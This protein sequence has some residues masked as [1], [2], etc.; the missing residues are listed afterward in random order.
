MNKYQL[1]RNNL[2]QIPINDDYKDKIFSLASSH[3][4]AE[5]EDFI[6]TNSISLKVKNDKNETIIHALLKGESPTPENELLRCMKFLVE[7]GA[8]IS[9]ID[10]EYLTPLFICIKKEYPEIFKYLITQ[11][12]NT[13]IK[14][15]D[16]LNVLHVI[17]KPGHTIFDP[18]GIQDLIPERLPKITMEG[19][20]DV[21]KKIQ[22][23]VDGD[24][25]SL[26]TFADIA[27]Q[28]Y[29]NDNKEE[30]FNNILLIDKA[31]KEP[32]NIYTI[33]NELFEKL[34]NS[35]SENED[36]KDVNEEDQ[37]QTLLTKLNIEI[38]K[39][40]MLEFNSK[41]ELS[42]LNLAKN[43]E[44]CIHY[45]FLNKPENTN[46]AIDII[47]ALAERIKL[48]YP[49]GGGG[50]QPLDQIRFIL[51]THFD[52][53]REII[54]SILVLPTLRISNIR[55]D[56]YTFIN[57]IKQ[58]L[59]NHISNIPVGGGLAIGAGGSV[60]AQITA[61]S[62][63]GNIIS[64]LI[65]SP[66]NLAVNA[67]AGTI[68]QNMRNALDHIIHPIVVPALPGV[69]DGV[70]QIPGGGPTPIQQ[71]I[72]NAST[73]AI[74]IVTQVDNL[75]T[76]INTAITGITTPA[77]LVAIPALNTI[78]LQLKVLAVLQT[79]IRSAMYATV[80]ARN[81]V[82]PAKV[83]NIS[84]VYAAVDAN[85]LEGVY[86]AANGFLVPTLSN[87][88]QLQD[89]LQKELSEQKVAIEAIVIATQQITLALLGNAAGGIPAPLAAL[90][91]EIVVNAI[92][93]ALVNIGASGNNI[94]T[95]ID[96]ANK[97][98][99]RAGAY[100]DAIATAIGI[101]VGTFIGN[102]A[103][104]ALNAANAAATVNNAAI[105]A[106]IAGNAL[107]A[108]NNA[109]AAAG[110][111]A[112]LVGA[113]ANAV[114]AVTNAVAVPN[115][116][117]DTAGTTA[118]VVAA[119]V[120]GASAA[121]VGA[122]AN[123]AVARATA[124]YIITTSKINAIKKIF[125][126][127]INAVREVI[128]AINA[129]TK[130][131]DINNIVINYIREQLVNDVTQAAATAAAAGGGVMP[132]G[133]VMNNINNNSA[134][135]GLIP[136][137]IKENL[138]RTNDIANDIGNKIREK[139]HT[140]LN[141]PIDPLQLPGVVVGVLAH[142]PGA[143]TIQQNITA[144]STAAIEIVTQVD[145][146]K[147]NIIAAITGIP[148][149]II[150]IPALNNEEM[151]LKVLAVLQTA[152]RS[153][154]HASVYAR[155]EVLPAKV[156][157]ISAVYAA[158]DANVLE[159]VYR[160]ISTPNVFLVSKL[161]N[162]DELQNKLQKELSEQKVAIEAIVRAGQQITLALLGNAAGGA[163]PQALID[164]PAAA[165]NLTPEIVVNAIE[166]ALRIPPIVPQQFKLDEENYNKLIESYKLINIPQK[167]INYNQNYEY[168]ENDN[169]IINK[170]E[171][172]DYKLTINVKRYYAI[173]YFNL[174]YTFNQYVKNCYVQIDIDK[175][176]IFTLYQNIQQIYKYKYIIYIFNKQKEGIE[177]L[178]NFTPIYN[179]FYKK[180]EL[181]N[182]QDI[183]NNIQSIENHLSKIIKL[184]NE[185]IKSFNNFNASKIE[186][187]MAANKISIG[188]YPE[189][190]KEF[191]Y[192]NIVDTID[193]EN[194][195]I[196]N[197]CRNHNNDNYV[198]YNKYKQN[199]F[200]NFVL[201]FQDI[202]KFDDGIVAGPN[203][204]NDIPNKM[205]YN[206]NNNTNND[207]DIKKKAYKLYFYNPKY[208]KKHIQ[209]KISNLL[210]LARITQ[211]DI[212]NLK[213]NNPI[214]QR[215]FT[216]DIK[217]FILNEIL[218]EKF[219]TFLTN[220]I[221]NVFKEKTNINLLNTP[222]DY[223]SDI[224][225]PNLQ[226]IIFES[227]GFKHILNPNYEFQNNKF[228]SISKNRFLEMILYFD[229]NYFKQTNF[230]KFEYYKH[231]KFINNLTS[232]S[233]NKL[234]NQVDTKGWTPIYYAIDGN[235][236]K[237]I[238]D[239][240]T[241]NKDILKKYDYK[242]MSP[243]RLCINN[244]LQHLNYLFNDDEKIHF[245]D[246][247]K[248]ML[249]KEL[250]NNDVL[251]P[252][253]IDA[254]F[255]ITLHIL[256]DI[257]HN[258]QQLPNDMPIN[259]IK[260]QIYTEY[261]SIVIDKQ[262]RTQEKNNKYIKNDNLIN[263]ALNERDR[264]YTPKQNIHYNY[265]NDSETNAILRKY[266]NKAGDLERTAFGLYGSYWNKFKKYDKLNH[267]HI[268]KQ[269]KKHLENLITI[270][271][272]NILKQPD[273][274]NTKI[275]KI[276]KK[277]AEIDNRLSHYL[278]FIN[279]RFNTNKDNAYIVFLN[280]IYVHVLANIIG[281]AFYLRIEELIISY[282]IDSNIVDIG[283]AV[284]IEQLKTL[285]QLLINN[286]LDDTNINYL[287]IKEEK[288]PE[289]VLKDTIKKI[290]E[291]LSLA[292]SIEIINTFETKVYP[293]YRDLY[294][295]TYKY[296][297]MF[298]SN[299]HKFIYNQYHRLDILMLLL[300]N[301]S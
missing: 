192:D 62:A 114:A 108:A 185:C 181:L 180:N 12:A 117:I 282:Y 92:K 296:L 191:D 66:P 196:A 254:V 291:S 281:V 222:I 67:T 27:K 90:T 26:Q 99:D 189:I 168:S 145:T 230:D 285:N 113:A 271:T 288:N 264:P 220:E 64:T 160:A 89:K 259:S 283:Q 248:E 252:L 80:Y 88:E 122:A 134:A 100:T 237:V 120:A 48:T 51:F 109:V 105:T 215:N 223:T 57:A 251:I 292:N 199:F 250:N 85:V 72:T 81:E 206:I 32:D 111:S 229:T 137:F 301:L 121:D 150:A 290:L 227:L 280:K 77:L 246:N 2:P 58:D 294:K 200:H 86:N 138:Q 188:I 60:D 71:N 236:Y 261:E 140:A 295:I 243:L 38:K 74:E 293:N 287:Y 151:Q 247:Y 275:K 235:N 249:R 102:N 1:S 164:P 133:V 135:N 136:N 127:N 65:A 162:Q 93:Q 25:T 177:N 203:L 213:N 179:N 154:M 30:D 253:N 228:F 242:N 255:N 195:I 50:V 104:V 233:I 118:A 278:N 119:A 240:L 59:V 75:K 241:S 276:K 161:S 87:Q 198:E 15:Y 44:L 173:D 78:E 31:M 174:L 284:I 209:G 197:Y 263:N 194:E 182:L 175:N 110:G 232:L 11:S 69:V 16:N 231:N 52:A 169:N 9:N 61:I 257:M 176:N 214:I 84:A 269:F 73:A 171:I 262:E 300:N 63:G 131:K 224:K 3:E 297:K 91:P 299:Y 267:I 68:G 103:A 212:Q 238:K 159:G 268:I 186:K 163:L 201:F 94:K 141:H 132:V 128:L 289:L 216:N 130:V 167:Y 116:T 46:I 96:L 143:A 76:A 20:D 5:L 273:Y 4:L 270:E 225:K 70:L 157:N 274:D 29:D 40:N 37:L 56:L 129:A 279:I 170:N 24:N 98:A 22:D 7:R 53:V 41:L 207:A 82:L 101:A 226:Q 139:I 33:K 202:G 205:D 124:A 258:I 126:T 155:N 172:T 184:A 34:K 107:L 208:L 35:L 10:K 190:K 245:L 260:E 36:N 14:T 277:L 272:E 256:N 211:I 18:K 43:L 266:Y 54:L 183:E 204:L 17:V 218:K 45:F 23:V 147:T 244:Q 210:N 152:I 193:D 221:N 8:P 298:I 239:M 178:L 234:L 115:N 158:V 123:N 106:A 148:A 217:N 55:K 265:I 28:F 21:Y 95:I 97:A 219:Y 165:A 39:D 112:I 83:T 13:D 42:I 156:T 153:A 79:A 6:T 187:D 286:K 125:I 142:N 144:A 47:I 146:L 49:I 19:Y 166:K 149:A